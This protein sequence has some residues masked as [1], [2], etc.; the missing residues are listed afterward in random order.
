MRANSGAYSGYAVMVYK[1]IKVPKLPYYIYASW[2]QRADDQWHFGGDNNYKTFDYSDGQD[3]YAD[4]SW[5]ICYGPPH[6]DS[7]TRRRAV[8]DRDRHPAGE[9]R[10]QRTQRLVGQRREPHG[11]PVV[12]GRDHGQSH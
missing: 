4:K 10:P 2:Y 1:T 7:N 9:P 11:R 3:P 6:P 5:Y 12:E 8:V